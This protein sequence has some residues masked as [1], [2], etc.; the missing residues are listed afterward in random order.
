MKTR[1]SPPTLALDPASALYAM[2]RAPLEFFSRLAR[3]HGDFVQFRLG[4]HEHALYFLNH[5][6]LVR[7]VLVTQDRHFTKWFSVPRIFEV[8]GE[9]LFVSEGDFHMR[10]RRLA[11]PAFHRER[12]AAYAD[13]MAALAVQLRE[14]WRAG[15]TVDISQE[16]NWL[17]MMIVARTLFGADVEAEA[18]EI[19]DALSEILDQFERSTLPR[20]DRKDFEN[21]MSRLDAVVYRMIADRRATRSDRGD[22]LTMLLN[23]RDEEGGGMTDLQVRDEAMTIFLA[24]HETSANAL[25][26]CWYLLGKHPEVERRF[27]D[28][29]DRALNGQVPTLGDIPRLVFTGCVFSEAL[30]LYPPVWA[31]GRQAR[32]DL[33]LGEYEVAGGAVVIVSPYVTQRDAR[34]FPSPETF[35]PERWLPEEKAQRPRYSYFPFSAGSRSCLGEMF[36]GVEGVLALAC[37]GQKW[38][39]RPVLE[40]KVALQPQLTLRARHGIKVEVEARTQTAVAP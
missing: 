28:E 12:I 3:E 20:A 31:I 27:H 7:E 9:G 26:W 29:V 22:L 6:D 34:W 39:L 33:V 15:T 19:R 5:P 18:N 23:A 38:R 11:Q 17:A 16:M 14:R 2:R 25:A 35:E 8:L 21:A 40:Q 32:R 30:R 4:D 10:Q 1:P 24:G 37:I 36:A 13:E